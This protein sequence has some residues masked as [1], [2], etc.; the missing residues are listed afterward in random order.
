MN[1]GVVMFDQWK[2]GFDAWER[3]TSNY[4]DEWLKSPAALEPSGF[5]LSALMRMKKASDAA[6]ASWWGAM[7]LPTR[8]MQERTLHEIHRMQS[9]ILDLEEQLAAERRA[10]PRTARPDGAVGPNG[11]GDGGRG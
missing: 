10:R 4:L 5:L 8:D 9:K 7:G 1:Q 3:S 11:A 2:K 6:M